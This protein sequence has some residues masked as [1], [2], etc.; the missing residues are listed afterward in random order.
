VFRCRA[1]RRQRGPGLVNLTAGCL[2]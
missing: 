2:R 1:F